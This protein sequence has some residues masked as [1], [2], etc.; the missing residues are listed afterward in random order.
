MGGRDFS[1]CWFTPQ[2]S[3]ISRT[4]PSHSQSQNP[5]IKL[6]YG[7]QRPMY[8]SHH[9]L[10]PG[11]TLSGSLRGNMGDRTRTKHLVGCRLPK[12]H[13]NCH[14]WL[15]CLD[16]GQA[17]S[18]ELSWSLNK[19]LRP[20]R[21][22]A[23]SQEACLALRLIRIVEPFSGIPSHGWSENQTLLTIRRCFSQRWAP[24]DKKNEWKCSPGCN[25]LHRGASLWPIL[26]L[27]NN[28]LVPSTGSL[29]HSG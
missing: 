15:T 22:L 10:S 2:M 28:F 7:W 9:L 16:P 12:W 20:Q 13:L 25:L 1:I 23:I 5:K 19:H 11:C 18:R 27:S 26:P 24:Q 8:S 3:M 14:P 6:R 21:D 29:S 17:C 4:G